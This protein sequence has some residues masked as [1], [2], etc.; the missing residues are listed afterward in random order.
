MSPTSLQNGCCPPHLANPR[1][2]RWDTVTSHK[3]TTPTATTWWSGLFLWDRSCSQIRC[4][5]LRI[6]LTD[7]WSQLWLANELLLPSDNIYTS[8]RG[9]HGGL[10]APVVKD[11]HHLIL[12]YHMIYAIYTCQYLPVCL[13]L[14]SFQMLDFL[15]FTFDWDIKN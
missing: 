10:W 5:Y 12:F 1:L 2:H 13:S 6:N 9:C 11:I 4:F 7:V 14:C 8:Y 15:F 3:K